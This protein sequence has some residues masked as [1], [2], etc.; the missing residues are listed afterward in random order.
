M[1]NIF[2]IKLF[3]RNLELLRSMTG[4]SKRNFCY[5]LKIENAYRKDF[6]ALGLKMEIGITNNF[7]GVDKTW[8]L[9]EHPEGIE[10]I[11]FTPWQNTDMQDH[12]VGNRHNVNESPADYSRRLTDNL[13]PFTSEHQS[14][15]QN[16][17]EAVRYTR[18]AFDILSSGTGYASALKEN[19]KAFAEAIQDKKTVN[20]LDERLKSIEERLP[21]T[22]G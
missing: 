9:T 2:D 8:L 15:V 3:H 1:S 5:L 22:E 20:E 12:P 21:K 19:I 7:K 18:L 4:L 13:I 14:H 6:K 11:N 17:D 16:L 10:G